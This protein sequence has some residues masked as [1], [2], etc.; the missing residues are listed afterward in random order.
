MYMYVYVCMYV[1]MY[2]CI[3]INTYIY[4]F[5]YI[6]IYVHIQYAIHTG[7]SQRTLRGNAGGILQGDRIFEGFRAKP[8]G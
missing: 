7:R 6:D 2:V 5:M 1:C 8:S 3:H 4:I